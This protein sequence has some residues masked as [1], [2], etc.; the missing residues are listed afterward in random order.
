M[1]ELKDLL[2][3]RRKMVDKKATQ[4]REIRDDWN[5]KT[6]EYTTS[7][8]E[9][10]NEVRD[11]IVQVRE[12][13]ELRDQMNEMVREKKKERDDANKA[14]RDAKDS[15][16]TSQPEQT[17]QF[18]ARGRPIRPDTVQSLSRTMERLEREF[19]QGKHTG[20]NEKK[21]FKTMKELGAK[22]KALEDAQT[23][24][25]GT[26][27]SPDYRAAVAVQEAAHAAVKEA[28]DAAQSAHDLM[29]EWNAEVDRQREKAE[30][31][32][33][34]LRTSKKE[35]DK[36]HSMYIVGLRCLHSIQD[37]LRA[38]RGATAGEGQ[39]TV[40]NDET[41]NLMAK[42]LAGETLST[43]ELMQLHRND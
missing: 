35:A 29:I 14:V 42:L 24:S 10:N 9:L 7:R 43:E 2:E 31:A 1:V 28:A 34:K 25:L 23:P 4:H 20:K 11:L 15:V 13:R 17:Q 5:E 38:M 32:H 19:E 3:E 36:E 8:N 22:K 12:Q 27:A 18:D 26:D 39:R 21:Y 37:I 33:R 41:Q 6:K 30:V 16:R 40:A